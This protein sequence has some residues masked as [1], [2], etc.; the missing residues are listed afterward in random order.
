MWSQDPRVLTV[1]PFPVEISWC[2][3]QWV[4]S[5]LCGMIHKAS[6]LWRKL[7][8]PAMALTTSPLNLILWQC[9]SACSFPAWSNR[10]L[11]DDGHVVCPSSLSN[12]GA[13]NHTG[14]QVL[15]IWLVQLNGWFYLMLININ[16]NANGHMWPVATTLG[17]VVLDRVT[18]SIFAH[19]KGHI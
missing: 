14:Y 18:N 11:C 4:K 10:N 8:S 9:S 2:L 15:K 1:W 12:A 5:E 19:S 16:L 7:L 17:N 6:I 13:T 3:A